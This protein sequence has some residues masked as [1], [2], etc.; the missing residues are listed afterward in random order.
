MQNQ[1][2]Y[3]DLCTSTFHMVLLNY[4]K[5]NHYILN[6]VHLYLFLCP[7]LVY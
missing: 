3:L 2:L 5:N 4:L 7:N 6:Q 1:Q